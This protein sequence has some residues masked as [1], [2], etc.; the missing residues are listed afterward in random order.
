M[1]ESRQ[2]FPLLTTMG[3]ILSHFPQRGLDKRSISVQGPYETPI[4]GKV[5]VALPD[6]RQL[7]KLRQEYAQTEVKSNDWGDS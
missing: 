7:R 4:I 6:K 3:C 1:P 2:Q 5:T